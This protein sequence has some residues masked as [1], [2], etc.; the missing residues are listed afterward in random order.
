MKNLE[1]KAY[2][3]DVVQVVQI[4]ESL[5]IE[6]EWTHHQVDTYFKI[7]D[8]KLK[9]REVAGE[10][11]ELI[12]YR[13]PGKKGARISDYSLFQ[14]HSGE[15]LKRVLGLALQIDL[16]VEKSRTL[17]LWKNVRIHLDKVFGLG[18]FIEFEAVLSENAGTDE[19][20]DRIQ[21]LREKLQIKDA[22]FIADGYY[23]LFKMAEIG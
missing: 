4:V 20:E 5:G 2:C 12:F 3:P 21:F 8:G 18:D 15:S 23:E 22:H 17:Y 7:P 16:V 9:L 1:L 13:R 6:K 19:S 10:S 14:T 11:A